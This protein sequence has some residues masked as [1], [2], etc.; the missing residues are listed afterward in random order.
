M[1]APGH[2]RT[3]LTDAVAT[4]TV[5]MVH[6]LPPQAS[7]LLGRAVELEG[8]RRRLVT[9][10]T[11]LLTVTG[12]PGTGKTR[13]AL[14]IAAS[15]VDEFADG[16]WFVDLTLVTDAAGVLPQIGSTFGLRGPGSES[17]PD[18]Q[19]RL[20]LAQRQLLL[21]LDNCEHVLGAGPAIAALLDACPEIVVLAT[22]REPLRVRWERLYPLEPL[23]TPPAGR[24]LP[25]DVLESIPSV[26]L[27]VRQARD[28]RPDFRLDADNAPTIAE[29]CRRLDGLPL[30]IELAAARS[31]ALPPVTILA[32][33]ERRLDLLVGGRR[34]EPAR[35][36]T[37]RAALDWSYELLHPAE[38][39]LF[40]RLGV[41]IGGFTVEAA[42][43]VYEQ[44]A[45]AGMDVLDGL[46]ALVDRGLLKQEETAGEPRFTLLETMRAYALEALETRGEASAARRRHAE[47][48]GRLVDTA[49]VQLRGPDQMRWLECLDRELSNIRAALVWLTGQAEDIEAIRLGL[50]IGGSMWWYMHVRGSYV[51]IRDLLLPLLEVAKRSGADGDVD[52]HGRALATVGVAVWGLG[53]YATARRLHDEA[54]MAFREHGDVANACQMLIDLSCDTVAQGDQSAAKA[55]TAEALELGSDLGDEWMSAWA[56]TFQGM[57]AIA[58]G[59]LESAKA[60]FD[61]A[62]RLRRQIGDLF[63]QAWASH[64]LASVERIRGDAATARPLYEDALITFRALGE[65]PTVASILDALGELAL[66][67]RDFGE[68]R[69]RFG[70]GLALYREMD[71]RRG[72]GIAISGFAAVAA[73]QGQPERA[74]RLAGA[75]TALHQAGGGAIELVKPRGS[76]AWLDDARRALGD[77]AA[78][79]AWASGLSLSVDDAIDEALADAPSAPTRT[80]PSR[81]EMPLTPREQEVARLVAHGASNRRIAEVLVI[82]ERTAEAHISNILAKLG[83]ETRVQLAAWTVARGLADPLP[84]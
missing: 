60:R 57:L 69:T 12:T 64:G 83:L 20:Y 30:A 6:N 75:A 3:V 19:L 15:L 5:A 76:A 43:E 13:L 22:S 34:D 66:A 71:S 72:I 65:R 40:R 73:A 49:A 36:Q 18:D 37:I 68:A 78:A 4:T 33:L 45:E 77:A 31:R 29:L 24:A 46:G 41:F 17:A 63:G 47:F 42:V 7:A 14:A 8:A 32:R 38:Q 67:E 53:D 27:F 51:E 81:R 16:V 79:S 10:Q 82:G 23:A 74:V 25:P 84:G 26:A 2:V 35:H 1:V 44:P 80:M 55:V 58:E 50:R 52:A 21:L 62:M 28:V 56:L 54:L 11:R 70:E 61:S 48:Y 9:E 59:D 39:V